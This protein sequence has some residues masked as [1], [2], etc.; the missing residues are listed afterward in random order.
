MCAYVFVHMSNGERV[1]RKDVCYSCSETLK[2]AA[3]THQAEVHWR[4]LDSVLRGN[5]TLLAANGRGGYGP[6]DCLWFRGIERTVPTRSHSGP[7]IT[8][9]FSLSQLCRSRG[10]GNTAFSGRF[11]YFYIVTTS[12][13]ADKKRNEGQMGKIAK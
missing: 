5:S 4:P 11:C 13:L 2:P 6:R 7:C 3:G 10:R 9:S 1:G 8:L 12:R